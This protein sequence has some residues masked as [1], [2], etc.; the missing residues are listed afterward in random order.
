MLDSAVRLLEKKVEFTDVNTLGKV[1]TKADIAS[2]DKNT[3]LAPAAF[4]PVFK[5]DGK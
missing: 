1:W 4:R 5:F 2:L 3:V